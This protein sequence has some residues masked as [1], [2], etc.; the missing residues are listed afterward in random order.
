MVDKSS[1]WIGDQLRITTLNIVGTYE[2]EDNLGC[3]KVKYLGKIHYHSP[4]EVE[5]HTGVEEPQ[6][7]SF[8][9]IIDPN[10]D[11][12]KK[13]SSHKEIDLH[14]EKLNHN[15]RNSPAE[16]VLDYQLKA[17]EEFLQNAIQKKYF[18][19]FIIHGKG[20]GKLKTLVHNMLDSYVEVKMKVTMNQDGATE[21]WLSY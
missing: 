16:T 3:L 14:I 13:L 6:A 8:D 19:I 7:I 17:A 11:K 9:D 5:L 12:A 18:K 21:V 1:L 10:K 15:F 4:A 20:E 2:G